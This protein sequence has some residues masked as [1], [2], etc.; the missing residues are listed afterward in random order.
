MINHFLEIKILAHRNTVEDFSNIKKKFATT[1][2]NLTL[3]RIGFRIRGA[4]WYIYRHTKKSQL[5]NI[6]EGP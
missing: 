3:T 5:G 1:P 2:G 4:R 6:F